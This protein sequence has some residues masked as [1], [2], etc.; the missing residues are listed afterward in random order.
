MLEIFLKARWVLILKTT[1]NPHILFQLKLKIIS[2]LKAKADKATE[3]ILATD[4]DREGEA[5]SWHLVSALKL[6]N[7]DPKELYSMKL[8]KPRLMRL[9]AHPRNLNMHLVDAQQAR[10]IL[11]RLVGYGLSPFIW[12]KSVMVCQL[13]GFSLLLYV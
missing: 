3:V 2:E 7:K 4:E 13:E 1:L 6:K 10:R 12:K 5:I 8:L 9:L 11:D